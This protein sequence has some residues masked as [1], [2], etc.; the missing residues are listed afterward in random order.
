MAQ[1]SGKDFSEIL[2]PV[3]FTSVSPPR[4][5]RACAGRR[6][7][8]PLRPGVIRAP[9]PGWRGPRWVGRGRTR[10]IPRRPHP[11]GWGGG[12][13]EGL[14]GVGGPGVLKEKCLIV[15]LRNCNKIP[16]WP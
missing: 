8:A 16:T 4:D 7:T 2:K 1:P 11:R 6:R 15:F 10:T 3:C 5:G 13:R 12:R 14:E 9:L